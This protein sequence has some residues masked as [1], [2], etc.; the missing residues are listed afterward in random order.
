MRFFPTPIQKQQN[1]ESSAI[2]V[3]WGNMIMSKDPVEFM[4]TSS[5]PPEEDQAEDTGRVIRC[6]FS[7]ARQEEKVSL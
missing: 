5:I 7:P 3:F 6:D 2:T 1:Q 4:P